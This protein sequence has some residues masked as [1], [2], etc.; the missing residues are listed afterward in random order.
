MQTRPHFKT[1]ERKAAL[2]H[3]SLVLLCCQVVPVTLSTHIWLGTNCALR[4]NAVHRCWLYPWLR[5]A[6]LPCAY[7]LAY[8]KACTHRHHPTTGAPCSAQHQ[9]P[10][11]RHWCSCKPTNSYGSAPPTKITAAHASPEHT[12]RVT[13][14]CK[15]R[16]HTASHDSMQRRRSSSLR[17]RCGRGV[18]IS[19]E[20]SGRG[21]GKSLLAFERLPSAVRGRVASRLACGAVLAAQLLRLLPCTHALMHFRYSCMLSVPVAAGSRWRVCTCVGQSVDFCTVAAILS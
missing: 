18:E 14:R 4:P 1:Q 7:M 3:I 13:T 19:A 11:P 21:F 9:P 15:P 20:G 8:H 6:R 5:L 17:G 12:S 10:E 2:L 16:Q